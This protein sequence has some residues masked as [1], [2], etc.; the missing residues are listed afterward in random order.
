M[1]AGRSAKD[2]IILLAVILVA[3]GGIAGFG[4][5][6]EEVSGY[7]RLQAWNTSPLVEKTRE[8]VQ[9]AAAD[10]AAKVEG[11]IAA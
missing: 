6:Q 10:D 9:A 8:F 11:M 3:V 4:F 2:V 7:L 1:S 5:F